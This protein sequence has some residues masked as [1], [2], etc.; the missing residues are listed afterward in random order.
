MR[1]HALET[2]A[3]AIRERQ[4]TGAGALRRVRT[5]VT[6]SPWTEIPVRAWLID[7]P[8]G[9][10]VV[11]TG[12]SARFAEP[13]YLPRENL[14]ARRNLRWRMTPDQE[15]GPR[16]REL[17][18]DPGEIRYTV[19]THLHLDHDGGL[20]HVKRSE[21]V[22][23]DTE[24]RLARGLAGRLRGYLPHRWPAG[25]APRTIT[26]REEPYGPFP[27][28]FELAPGVVLVGT[29]GHTPGHLSVV[30]EESP[31]LFLAGD[32]A[33]NE[34][35]LERGVPDGIA[36]SATQARETMARIRTFAA[37]RD[38]V[39]LPTHD[40]DAPARLGREAAVLAP[41]SQVAAPGDVA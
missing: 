32:A 19:L 1:V 9:L 28:S 10:I 39:I 7:H 6:R 36:T 34:P 41:R 31:R 4:L 16:L 33:Y 3:V 8:D 11:D 2:G 40:P 26:L 30:V 21:I 25:F 22:V 35:A 24:Y 18:V 17:G 14:H 23:T 15:L 27:R 5:L 29:P 12:Q 13:G 20:E 37:E 38:V